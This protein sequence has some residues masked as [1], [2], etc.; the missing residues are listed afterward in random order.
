MPYDALVER[1]IPVPRAT[2]FAALVDF[3]GVKKLLPDA[4]E[5]CAC[6]GDGVGAERTIVLNGGGRVVERLEVVHD[7]SVY[8]YTILE[9]DALPVEQYFAVVTLSDTGKGTHVAW[10]SNWKPRGA[11]EDSVRESLEGLYNALID[12]LA[13]LSA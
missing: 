8:G 9:T 6:I 7:D 11:D 12:G 4:V 10:G 2:V 13:R 5:S 1:E 3:G